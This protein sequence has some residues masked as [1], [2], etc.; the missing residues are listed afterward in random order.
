MNKKTIIIISSIVAVIGIVCL[1]IFLFAGGS[2]FDENYV[3]DGKSLLGKWCEE[4]YEESSYISY[5]FFE[6]GTVELVEYSYGIEMKKIVGTYSV[7][8]NEIIIDYEKYN[9]NIEHSE[10]KFCITES[11]KLVIIYLSN[12]DQI[13]EEE[14]VLIPF[15]VKFN[16]DNSEIVGLWEDSANPGEY[17]TF[18]KDYTGTVSTI[19]DKD[20]KFEYGLVY[21]VADGYFYIAFEFV[22]GVKQYLVEFEYEVDGDTLY[23]EG[24]FNGE[25][26]EYTF[27]R[28]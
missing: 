18:N 4:D 16:E 6:N 15:D 3:Y 8:V 26:L 23:L 11:G 28:S 27:K 1:C 12:N 20:E 21:S 7:K 9:G 2:E 10:N 19:V 14:M 24:E 17:W 22:P 25:V 5:E 13:T